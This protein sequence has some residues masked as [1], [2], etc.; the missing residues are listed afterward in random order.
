MF[1]KAVSGFWADDFEL[2]EGF[3]DQYFI[4]DTH[5]PQ[6]VD[7]P[8]RNYNL[9]IYLSD[10]SL[11]D[12]LRVFL[13]D[14]ANNIRE[15]VIA[16]SDIPVPLESSQKLIVYR[17]PYDPYSITADVDLY[18]QFDSPA[19][20][21]Y[22]IIM[23]DI[24]GNP[25][26]Y[27]FRDGLPVPGIIVGNDEKNVLIPGSEN[28]IRHRFKINGSSFRNLPNGIYPILLLENGDHNDK[29]IFSILR[30]G[31]N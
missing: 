30:G 14:R 23:L 21:R 10:L 8:S 24:N 20:S 9:E 22:N 7:S 2:S 13:F 18:I 31:V 15:T 16:L 3:G 12:S 17:S 26:T 19:N 6:S 11:V 29:F 28:L 27:L 5:I 4:F 1:R 25:I